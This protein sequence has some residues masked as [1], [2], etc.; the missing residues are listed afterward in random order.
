M[1]VAYV[2]K[3]VISIITVEETSFLCHNGFKYSH[4]VSEKKQAVHHVQ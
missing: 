3:L 4:I 2:V 1:Y